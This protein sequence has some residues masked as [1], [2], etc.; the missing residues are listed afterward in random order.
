MAHL[1]TEVMTPQPIV[2]SR[3]AT[4][5]SAAQAMRDADIGDVIVTDGNVI[6]GIVT[7]RDLAVRVVAEGRH[8]ETTL[9][10]DVCGGEVIAVQ[11]ETSVDDAVE[12]MRRNAVRRLPVCEADGVPVG[13]VSLG[14]LAI[15]RDPRSALSQISAAP[16]NG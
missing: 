3:D 7:D 5:A 4:A 13:V 2:L 14:D 10:A 15:E 12:V 8:P 1:V 9:L 16:P 11:P 6:C